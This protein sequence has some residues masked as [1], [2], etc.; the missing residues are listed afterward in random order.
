MHTS[1]LRATRRPGRKCVPLHRASRHAW[2]DINP[3][4]MRALREQDISSVE[5]DGD[6]S[7]RMVARSNVVVSGC[8]IPTGTLI[9]FE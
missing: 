2:I 7:R 3:G 5:G 6:G 1:T 8:K 4:V 9:E